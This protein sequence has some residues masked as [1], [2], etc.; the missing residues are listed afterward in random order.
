MGDGI[1]YEEA[2][3]KHEPLSSHERGLVEGIYRYAW[4]RD[5]VFYVGTNGHTL[6]EAVDLAITEYRSANASIRPGWSAEDLEDVERANTV[7]AKIAIEYGLPRT[8]EALVER[9]AYAYARG[10]T[11]GYKDAAAKGLAAM[12]QL[13]VDLG[14]VDAS[15]GL[16]DPSDAEVRL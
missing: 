1:R 16:S 9:L 14:D 10:I 12:R 13:G 7:A 4:M 2:V 8:L 6:G 5:G 3:A 11:D 15:D